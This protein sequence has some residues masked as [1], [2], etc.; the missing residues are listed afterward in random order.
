LSD[1]RSEVREARSEA[2]AERLAEPSRVRRE[3]TTRSR[4]PVALLLLLAAA[5][6]ARAAEERRKVAVL[7][8]RAGAEGAPDL[9][10]RTA[11][12]LRKLAALTVID[13]QEARRRN[14]RVDAQL[15][16]C[17]GNASCVSRAGVTVE[18]DEVLLVAVSQLGDL[19][20]NLQRIDVEGEKVAAQH[21]EVLSEGAVPEA[22]ID[23]RIDEWLKKLYPPEVFKRYGF[24]AVTSNVDG[25]KVTINEKDAGETPLPDK[26]RVLAPRNYHVGLTRSGYLPFSARIDVVPD[27]SVEVRAELSPETASVPWYKRWYVWGIVGGVA[28]G[29]AIGTAVYLT[30]PDQLHDAG[31]VVLPPPSK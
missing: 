9:G 28:A 15:A 25:A 14:P 2:N 6:P 29:V 20:V 31:F 24:I 27:S 30:R 3:G 21:S 11:A 26:I 22:K 19:V 1:A 17:A 13:P 7:E 8:Y 4:R 16:R 5:A 18:A 12:R 23:E 10:A